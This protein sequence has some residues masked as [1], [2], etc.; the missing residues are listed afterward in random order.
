MLGKTIL[1]I[2]VSLTATNCLHAD[3]CLHLFFSKKYQD[4]IDCYLSRNETERS[5]FDEERIILCNIQLG[6]YE[7]AESQINKFFI[8]DSSNSSF[9]SELSFSFFDK[10]QY[11]KAIQWLKNQ[12]KIE[13]KDQER[14]KLSLCRSLISIGTI[15][16]QN[17]N[18]HNKA[19]EFFNFA[20]KLGYPYPLEYVF[21]NE[22]WYYITKNKTEYFYFLKK[23]IQKKD[24]NYLCWIMTYWDGRKS[25]N[26][27][28]DD[29]MDCRVIDSTYSLFPDLN[30]DSCMNLY[31]SSVAAI[32]KEKENHVKTKNLY[33]FDLVN[34][35][36]R[37]IQFI[38]YDALEEVKAG[39]VIDLKKEPNE[40]WE[41]TTPNSIGEL[42]LDC[43]KNQ[44]RKKK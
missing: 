31:Y 26:Y 40:G 24:T 4:A 37:L 41:Y 36:L 25:G 1:I 11:Q 19:I 20:N 42:W 38:N 27:F 8:K 15:Y 32:A 17:L 5:S 13:V 9:C 7:K 12:I 44:V 3:D 6:N 23:S 35:R 22:G 14:N 28:L 2:F 29:L 39:S 34:S 30:I 10:Q 21:E 33:E 18:D 43:V 16:E